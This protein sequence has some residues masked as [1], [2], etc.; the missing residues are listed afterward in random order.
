MSVS[1][2]QKLKIKTKL[3]SLHPP[4]PQ[5]IKLIQK[6]CQVNEQNNNKNHSCTVTEKLK[7]DIVTKKISKKFFFKWKK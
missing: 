1:V 3:Q 4:P 7:I 2:N 6:N 5:Q